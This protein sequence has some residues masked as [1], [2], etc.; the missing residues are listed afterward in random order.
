MLPNKCSTWVKVLSYI[1]SVQKAL[2]YQEHQVLCF[3]VTERRDVFHNWSWTC[4]HNCW[5]VWNQSWR[6]T[7]NC[8][9]Q[10]GPDHSASALPPPPFIKPHLMGVWAEFVEHLTDAWPPPCGSLLHNLCRG[11][12]VLQ[13]G[14]T[15]LKMFGNCWPPG[16]DQRPTGTWPE[17][18]TG[19]E[20][21]QNLTWRPCWNRSRA[22]QFLMLI[23]PLGANRDQE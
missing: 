20:A 9:P 10:P 7:Q 21:S 23:S 17:A 13:L 16:P 15:R 5:L 22:K 8:R 1:P 19:L 12:V 18:L 14:G 3:F 4:D 2:D 6:Q 11:V